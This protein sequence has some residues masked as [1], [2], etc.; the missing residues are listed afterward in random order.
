M[1]IF[2]SRG[3]E[4]EIT[5][6][7]IQVVENGESLPAYWSYPRMGSR[8]PTVALVHDWWGITPLVRRMANFFA[9]SGYYVIV[10]DLFLG[11]T[12]ATGPEAIALV[13][14]L[15]DRGY[16]R[17]NAALSALE[18]HHQTNSDVAVLGLGMGGSLA[19]EAAILRGDL[20][21]AI[22]CYGFPGRYFGRLKQ[23]HAPILALY[24][25]A[26]PYVSAADIQRVRAELAASALAAENQVQ[27]LNHS[28]REIFAETTH[29]QDLEAGRTAINLILDF[30]EDHLRPPE[31]LHR[32]LR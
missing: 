31:R 24:S 23:T 29:T 6:G 14:A 21:A 4:Y 13:T 15:G 27:V 16:A 17:V 20:E 11:K 28:G 12:A 22:A 26:E 19:Y 7:V 10:P 25:Q 5:Q 30:L 3:V 1:S 8:C 18:Q 2:E 9:Q 32:N